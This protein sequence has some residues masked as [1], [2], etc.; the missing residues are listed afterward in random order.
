VVVVK[1]TDP[2]TYEETWS[3]PV[4]TRSARTYALPEASEVTVT[5]PINEVLPATV[6]VSVASDGFRPTLAIAA[7]RLL[8]KVPVLA[9]RLV[10]VRA[11]E[12]KRLPVMRA[13]AFARVRVLANRLVVVRALET[14][15]LPVMLAVAF[16]RVRVFADIELPTAKLVGVLIE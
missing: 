12:T 13:A 4:G 1:G 11:L 7:Y 16:E 14:K 2:V 8:E 9:N 6:K 10:V 5:L 15:R 3:E